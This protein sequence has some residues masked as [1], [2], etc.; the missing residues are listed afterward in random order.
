MLFEY[1]GNEERK[2]GARGGG[3][4]DGILVERSSSSN[5]DDNKPATQLATTIADQ[6]H[7]DRQSGLRLKFNDEQ[8]QYPLAVPSICFTIH[9]CHPHP[10][11]QPPHSH[12]PPTTTLPPHSFL[13]LLCIMFVTPILFPNPLSCC[14]HSY[15]SSC[16]PSKLLPPCPL[17]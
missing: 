11:S 6:E 7:L 5:D 3:R 15:D 4:L 9:R 1:L 13:T 16:A 8:V 10:K 2:G 12:L 14:S 17:H